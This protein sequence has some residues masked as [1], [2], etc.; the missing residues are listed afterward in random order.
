[1][2][3][4]ILNSML[5]FCSSLELSYLYDVKNITGAGIGT[6]GDLFS[7]AATGVGTD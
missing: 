1:M 4:I 2:P 3:D 7:V 6:G 5:F